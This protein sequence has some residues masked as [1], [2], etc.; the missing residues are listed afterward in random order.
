MRNEARNLMRFG[1][2]FCEDDKVV[3]PKII[4]NMTTD[5][6]LI[7]TFE[8]GQSLSSY[9]K[10]NKNIEEHKILARIGLRSFLK[11]ILVHN[12]IHADLHPGN[13]LVR[14]NPV[15]DELQLVLLDTGLISELSD[16]DWLHFKQ[17]FKCIVQG[18]GKGG[19]KLMVEHARQTNI[20]DEDKE[21]FVSEMDKLFHEMRTRKMSE[22]DIGLF[23]NNLLN[24]VRKYRVKIESNF[25]TLCIATVILEGIGRQ[26]DPDINILDQSIPLLIWSEKATVDDRIVFLRERLKDEFEMEDKNIPIWKKL[27]NIL[28]PVVSSFTD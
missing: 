17:L 13:I 28:R 6:V 24:T 9:I 26:L 7:E 2:N 5:D 19:A 21:K 8:H 14:K 27:S 1:R 23:L 22:I 10:S 15:T 4:E 11:M 25:A 3:F 20:S 12:F 16:T 18:D